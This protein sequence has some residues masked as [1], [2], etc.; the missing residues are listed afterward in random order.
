MGWRG[1]DM[2]LWRAWPLLV[3]LVF[4]ARPVQ[5][6][7]QEHEQSTTVIAP[8]G[9]GTEQAEEGEEAEEEELQERLTEREDKRRPLDPVTIDLAGRPLI[10]GGEVELETSTLWLRTGDSAQDRS[11][12]SFLELWIEAEAF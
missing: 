3:A 6:Q 12:R 2:A 4:A 8:S 11:A 10:I 9:D 5:A 1:D 7:E